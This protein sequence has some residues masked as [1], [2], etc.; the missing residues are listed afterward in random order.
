MRLRK[1]SMIPNPDKLRHRHYMIAK[2]AGDPDTA[3]QW[4]DRAENENWSAS[5]LADAIKDAL[6][7]TGSRHLLTTGASV[8]M[9]G[10]SVVLLLDENGDLLG[11]ERVAVRVYSEEEN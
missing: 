1:V 2:R 3:M 7:V 8:H 6:G 10:S 5:D 4:L 9:D 11:L